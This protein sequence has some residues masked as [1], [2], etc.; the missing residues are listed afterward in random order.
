M[1][2]INF[3][4]LFTKEEKSFDVYIICLKKVLRKNCCTS[5]LV[6]N[7]IFFLQKAVIEFMR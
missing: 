4:V 3:Y 7:E 5:K 1:A 2:Y 6:Y